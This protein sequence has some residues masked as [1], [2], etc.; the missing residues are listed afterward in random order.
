M[1]YEFFSVMLTRVRVI[2]QCFR[3]SVGFI[4]EIIVFINATVLGAT[5]V[6]GC[7]ELL[8]H[9]ARIRYT[10]SYRK[11]IRAHIELC[12]HVYVVIVKNKGVAASGWPRGTVDG[13]RASEP[14]ARPGI[15][16]PVIFQLLLFLV[17][18]A[19][20]N[21]PAAAALQRPDRRPTPRRST[22]LLRLLYMSPGE[23]CIGCL[24]EEVLIGAWP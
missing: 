9:A 12:I 16:E 10:L 1:F 6:R 8:V 14:A 11:L 23:A 19:R 13:S 21:L 4:V 3:V 22:S 18:V 24:L 2:A 7:R 17:D 5:C 15:P 20:I